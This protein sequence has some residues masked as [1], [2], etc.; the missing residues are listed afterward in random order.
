ML[1]Q[2]F[3]GGSQASMDEIYSFMGQALKWIDDTDWILAACPF[4]A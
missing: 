1:L 3:N 4:G 2:N